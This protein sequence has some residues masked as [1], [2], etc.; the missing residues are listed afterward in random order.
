MTWRSTGV[1][2]VGSCR[3][4]NHKRTS[5]ARHPPC[6]DHPGWAD[7]CSTQRSGLP[8]SSADAVRG[9][10]MLI[11]CVTKRRQVRGDRANDRFNRGTITDSSGQRII[12]KRQTYRNMQVSTDDACNYDDSL[13]I[14]CI[15]IITIRYQFS[16]APAIQFHCWHSVP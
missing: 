14:L 3:Y 2:T 16:R 9:R 5:A 6:S 7:I 15:G 13:R 10:C 11:Y 4:E 1:A 8:P 12:R